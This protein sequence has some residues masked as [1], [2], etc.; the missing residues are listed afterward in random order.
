MIFFIEGHVLKLIL[1]LRLFITGYRGWSIGKCLSNNFK[2]N[3]PNLVF[4]EDEKGGVEPK[5]L[6]FIFISCFFI[7]M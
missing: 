5:D 2:N 6:L 4:R 3:W 7:I 1:H